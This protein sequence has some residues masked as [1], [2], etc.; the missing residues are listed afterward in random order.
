VQWEGRPLIFDD[1]EEESFQSE[2]IVGDVFLH[3]LAG[4][5]EAALHSGTAW[6]C[7]MWAQN[8]VLRAEP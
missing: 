2:Q 3:F 4:A 7:A 5:G 1:S 8:L 6:Q